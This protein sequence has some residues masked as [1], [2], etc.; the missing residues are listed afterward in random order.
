MVLLNWILKLS[1]SGLKELAFNLWRVQVEILEGHLQEGS[2]YKTLLPGGYKTLFPGG[3][4][5]LC[6]ESAVYL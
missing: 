5:E 4:K 3:Y 6:T 1:L 2:A